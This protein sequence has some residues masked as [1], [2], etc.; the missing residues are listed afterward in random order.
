MFNISANEVV[1]A[2]KYC[3]EHIVSSAST[4]HINNSWM[5]VP[6]MFCITKLALFLVSSQKVETQ[7]LSRDHSVCRAAA[8]SHVVVLLRHSRQCYGALIIP[9]GLSCIHFTRLSWSSLSHGFGLG[10]LLRNHQERPR[11]IWHH[12]MTPILQVIQSLVLS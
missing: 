12:V 8:R 1:H 7:E 6:D 4:K 11:E 5:Q 3:D 10:R 2:L 9:Q